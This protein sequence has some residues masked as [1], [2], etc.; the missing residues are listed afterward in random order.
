MLY[1]GL[2]RSLGS[3][4]VGDDGVAGLM[5]WWLAIAAWLMG[6]QGEGAGAR[7]MGGGARVVRGEGQGSCGEGVRGGARVVRGE[8]AGLVW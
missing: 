5:W 2:A 7:V 8:W 3:Q 6:S 1:R 4:P